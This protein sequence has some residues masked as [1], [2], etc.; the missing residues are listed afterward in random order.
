LPKPEEFI[1]EENVH[2]PL[3]PRQKEVRVDDDTVKTSNRTPGEASI[4]SDEATCRGPLTFNPSPP[5]EE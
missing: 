4:T 3:E 2:L 5:R 1:A